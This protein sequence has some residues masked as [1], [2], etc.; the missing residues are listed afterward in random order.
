MGVYYYLVNDTKKQLGGCSG[1]WE[2]FDPVEEWKIAMENI[3][4]WSTEDTYR[5]LSD[6]GDYFHLPLS[7]PSPWKDQG[8]VLDGKMTLE[9]FKEKWP[10]YDVD[11]EE[12]YL[13]CVKLDGA[14][15]YEDTDPDWYAQILDKK[16]GYTHVYFRKDPPTPVPSPAKPIETPKATSAK[17]IIKKPI[18]PTTT[19]KGPAKTPV[20]VTKP[21]E[22]RERC[23]AFCINKKQCS[24]D[25]SKKGPVSN[26]C[27][28]HGNASLLKK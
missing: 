6:E 4:G 26:M 3:D 15:Y 8:K 19:A 28:Q 17:I 11:G 7:K 22:A 2:E 24:R 13:E 9:E 23:I 5:W 21:N 27:M 20:P 18:I 12:Y 25:V 1:K 10:G 14:A 16:T